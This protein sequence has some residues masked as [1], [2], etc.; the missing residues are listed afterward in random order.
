MGAPTTHC[1]AVAAAAASTPGSKPGAAAVSAPTATS[2]VLPMPTPP[3]TRTTGR[4]GTAPP[5]AGSATDGP[6]LR[7]HLST[8]G[9]RAAAGSPR[10]VLP[11]TWHR[12]VGHLSPDGIVRM[13]TAV[14][15]MR[16]SAADAALLKG[17]TCS[18]CVV[19]KMARS[20]FPLSVRV[21]SHP[22]EL[23][24]TDVCGPMPVASPGG[25]RYMVS[26]IDHATRFK[27]IVP[28]I[29][30][31]QATEA[32]MAVVNRWEVETGAAAN[33]IR[34][35]GGLEYSGG[36]WKAWREQKGIR[37][38]TSTRYT[39][40]QNGVA[41]RYNRTISERVG[42]LLADTGLHRRWWADLAVAATYLSNRTPHAGC[43]RT[44]F[45][46]FHSVRPHVGHLRALGS[47]AWV[48]LPAD[49]RR[50]LDPRA[51]EGVF[52]GYADCQEGYKV[53]VNGRVLTSRDVRFEENREL[54]APV[55]APLDPH[56]VVDPDD[57]ASV[58]SESPIEDAV[59]AARRLVEAYG[60]G[61]DAPP[62]DGDDGESRAE[63][64]Y[65]DTAPGCDLDPVPAATMGPE[66]ATTGAAATHHWAPDAGASAARRTLRSATR[67]SLPGSLPG[68][69][70]VGLGTK[71]KGKPVGDKMMIHQARREPDCPSFHEAMLKEV[72][73]L[74][75][76]GTWELVDLPEG[77][78]VTPTQ[79]QCERKRGPDGEITKYKGRVVV[80]GDTQVHLVNYFETWAPVARHATLR[81]LLAAV[82]AGGLTMGQLDIATAFLNG[83]VE[84]E[85]YP[86]T[87]G[88]RTRGPQQG[89]PPAQGTVWVQTG[90]TSMGKEAQGGPSGGRLHG[91]RRRPLP[92][93]GNRGGRPLLRPRLRGRPTAGEQVGG[94]CERR[95]K[96]RA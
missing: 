76:N 11:S 86:P 6:A 38:E 14:D 63:G 83:D 92:V 57:G 25:R 32:V 84:E 27:A 44:P 74:W 22:L 42:A 8:S 3:G 81:G 17:T 82:A 79:S 68:H 24:H 59:E 93:L 9:A 49:I 67:L 41:E 28:V 78:L 75:D 34:S 12:R 55:V 35:D 62:I 19:G 1:P 50:K 80:R 66:D 33:T 54:P 31:G 30:K 58:D 15:G 7:L 96:S 43:D 71:G 61:A 73:S 53:L 20:P 46:A 94:G 95:Q 88:V 29:S 91:H 85:V 65:D 37:H 4:T 90:L 72:Q 2:A 23:L 26:I 64:T 77:K 47:R 13:A 16:F 45:E 87:S 51:L 18:P 48:Y 36:K 56:P 89:R 40:Q 52:L 70:Y 60:V 10:D 5:P 69:A 39:P 21:A